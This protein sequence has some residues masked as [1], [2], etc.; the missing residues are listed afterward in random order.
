VNPHRRDAQTVEEVFIG[1]W[2]T[3][4]L[5]GYD[6]ASCLIKSDDLCVARGFT[7]DDGSRMKLR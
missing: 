5:G 3:G 7:C 2:G 1:E 6:Q 4:L